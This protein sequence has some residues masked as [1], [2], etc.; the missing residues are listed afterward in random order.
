MQRNPSPQ[1]K[2]GSKDVFDE[3]V[4]YT[5]LAATTMQEVAESVKVP[6]LASAAALVLSIVDAISV[7]SLLCIVWEKFWRKQSVKTNKKDI[8][9]ML[10]NIHQILCVII[11]LHATSDIEGVL[12]ISLLK[13]FG[14]FT[15]YVGQ[16]LEFNR[17]NWLI[18]VGYYK[19]YTPVC[20]SNSAQAKSNNYSDGQRLLPKF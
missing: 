15:E 2:T 6:F 17:W 10:E 7:S 12:S 1:M 9:D 11:G 18:I 3:I 14:R 5:T 20:K 4:Q 13:K 8:M 19:R 16:F